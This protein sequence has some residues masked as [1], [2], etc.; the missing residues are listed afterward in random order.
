MS[1]GQRPC[2]KLECFPLKAAAWE[3][4]NDKGHKWYS[5][6]LVKVYKDDRDGQWKETQSLT[7][8]DL[9]PAAGLLQTMWASLAV[10]EGSQGAQQ[11][12]QAAVPAVAEEP[13]PF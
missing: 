4:V 10:K 6:K 7:D 13:R 12:Q 9:L 11:Q 3:N 1:S 5:V 8:R 2:L